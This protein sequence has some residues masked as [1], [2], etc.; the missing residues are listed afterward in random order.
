MGGLTLPERRRIQSA[1]TGSDDPRQRAER[2]PRDSD[3]RVELRP[4]SEFWKGA[5]MLLLV[6]GVGVI[7]WGALSGSGWIRVCSPLDVFRL[8]AHLS[9]GCH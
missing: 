1:H 5:G 3:T 6:L 9:A 7:L 2:V 8:S 4:W